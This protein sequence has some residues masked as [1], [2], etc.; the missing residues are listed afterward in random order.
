MRKAKLVFSGVAWS[1]IQNILSILYGIVSV[2]FLLNYFGKEE[3]G[4]IGI[5]M[6]V[7]VYIQ[8][9]DMG[10]TDSNVRYFSEYIAKKDEDSIQKL[11]SMNYLLYLCIGLVNTILLVV[12]SLFTGTIFNVSAEQS[13]VLRNLLWVLALNATFSWLSACFGQYLQANDLISWIKKRNSF[14]KL[15]QFIIL[16][17][18]IQLHWDILTY[19]VCYTFA[20]TIILPWTVAKVKEVGPTIRLKLGFDKE[21]FHTV[22]PYALSVFSFS[23]FNFITM[24]SRTVILG[25]MKGPSSV[26]DYNILYAI[27]SVASLISGTFMAVLLP[28]VTKM[29]VTND[30]QG[31]NMIANK[32]TKYANLL[33]SLVIFAL[34]VGAKDIM[35]LYVGSGYDQLIVWLE[36]WLVVLLLSHRN[37]MTSLVFTEKKLTQVAVMG[38]FAMLC[39]IIAYIFLTPYIGVGAVVI[40]FAIHELIHTL[41]YYTYFLPK[42]FRIDTLNVALRSVLPTWITIAIS[43]L[44]IDSTITLQDNTLVELIARE[45]LYIMLSCLCIWYVLFNDQDKQIAK[46]IMYHKI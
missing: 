22:I 7:N 10:M 31:I 20:M 17:L 46:S 23:I 44:I 30:S 41:F 42:K 40:G 28:M 16:M 5:A 25:I 34:I 27:T 26:A 37:V 4:L 35:N 38:A 24:N 6:S 36:L 45:L 1:I 8:L 39:A 29:A 3:Y 11:L 9:L 12:L 18:T 32:G 19:F 13:L 43:A 33:I 21:T 15:L 2:P 14:L